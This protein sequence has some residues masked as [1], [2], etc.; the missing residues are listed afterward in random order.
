MNAAWPAPLNISTR[1]SAFVESP[2]IFLIAAAA[3]ASSSLATPTA[4]AAR[5]ADG[6][7]NRYVATVRGAQNVHDV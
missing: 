7:I 6:W 3:S 4:L 5:T 1:L 2:T